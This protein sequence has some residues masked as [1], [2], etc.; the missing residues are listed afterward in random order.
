MGAYW[1]LSIQ[2]FQDGKWHTALDWEV[3]TCCMS[4]PFAYAF[5]RLYHLNGWGNYRNPS[6]KAI[7]NL[8]LSRSQFQQFITYVYQLE[9]YH[10]TNPQPCTSEEQSVAVDDMLSEKV[11]FTNFGDL[12]KR[13][14]SDIEYTGG[15]VRAWKLMS[16]PLHRSTVR[17]R[18]DLC[19][20]DLIVESVQGV[21][22]DIPD[23]NVRICF[24]SSQTN[25]V[26]KKIRLALVNE[27]RS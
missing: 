4:V 23:R 6:K 19:N 21:T 26:G 14:F 17:A 24:N 13:E 2:F 16:L 1:I 7:N 27:N 15:L 9:A 25:E 5:R 10:A 18:Y 3:K 11:K 22:M 20:F 8:Y 12:I